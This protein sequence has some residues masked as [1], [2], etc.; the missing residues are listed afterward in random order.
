[1]RVNRF[2]PAPGSF[3][4]KRNS[5]ILLLLMG[6][7][8]K[9]SLPVIAIC[10]CKYADVWAVVARI[11]RT[12]QR[13]SHLLE[14]RYCG[15][16]VEVARNS[17]S[18]KQIISR[19]EDQDSG[20]IEEESKQS[21]PMA[22]RIGSNDWISRLEDSSSLPGSA[23]GNPSVRISLLPRTFNKIHSVQICP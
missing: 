22:P 23:V 10:L 7:C 4:W 20:G 13:Y 18:I 21:Y 15:T 11:Y 2:C 9:P 6:K 5:S 3:V 17:E 16:Y 19:E 14:E 12:K 8:K 1:M